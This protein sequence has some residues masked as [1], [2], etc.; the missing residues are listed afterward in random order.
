MRVVMRWKITG[1][2]NGDDWPDAGESIDLPDAEAADLIAGGL[3]TP[4]EKATAPAAG[5]A[6]AP[7][8][9][10]GKKPAPETR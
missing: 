5:K 7:K 1:T 3:A 2:R 10:V 8:P 6:A 4:A 9:R